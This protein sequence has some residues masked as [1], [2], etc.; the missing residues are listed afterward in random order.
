MVDYVSDTTI[1]LKHFRA[2]A[3]SGDAPESIE[4]QLQRM[5][6][7]DADVICNGAE[8]LYAHY[9]ELNNAGKRVCAELFNYGL[10]QNW[11]SFNREDRSQKIVSY[12]GRELGDE[13]A[14][15]PPSADEWPEPETNRNDGVDWR[16]PQSEPEPVPAP[17]P[18]EPE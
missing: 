8:I 10:N 4:D 5:P 11:T 6:G 13:G 18:A 16:D 9:P 14:I 1:L 2:F 7:T 17:A 15:Q 12:I 3:F